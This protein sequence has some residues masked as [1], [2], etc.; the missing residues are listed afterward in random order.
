MAPSN[1]A[2]SES[3][4]LL[5]SQLMNNVEAIATVKSFGA[6]DYE[7]ERIGRLS[8][9][10]RQS[11]HQ[12]EMRTLAYSHTVQVLAIS[13]LVGVILF[14]G[15]EVLSGAVSLAT[16]D[17]L[18]GTP[19]TLLMKLPELGVAVEQYHQTVSAFGR[20]LELRDLPVES[21]DT[22]TALDLASVDGEMVLERRDVRL[23]GALAGLARPVP[24]ARSW[25]DHGHRGRYRGG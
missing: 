3:K 22:G 18:L 24:A 11:Y 16:Y 17:A 1:A 25:K 15:F 23:P 8:D 6:E 2:S 5:N 19:M 10:S 13:A 14:G 4:S 21:A 12:I 7:I 9:T 20:V